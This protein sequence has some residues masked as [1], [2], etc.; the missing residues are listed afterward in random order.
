MNEIRLGDL[1]LA[2][3]EAGEGPPLVLLH[4]GLVDSRSWRWQLEGLAGDFRVLAWDAPGFGRSSDV[5]ESWRMED[6]ADAAAVWIRALGVERPHLLGLS[7]GSSI[8]LEVY[9]RH[10]DLPASLIL[11][12]AYAGWAG[13]LPP[14][15]VA[16]RLEGALAAAGL[17]P[18]EM[19]ERW[20]GVFSAAATSAVREELMAIWADNAGG[21]NPGGYRASVRSMADADLRNVLPRIRIP[22]LLLYGELDDRSPLPVARELHAGI[23]GSELVVLPGVGHMTSAEAPDAFDAEVRRFIRACEEAR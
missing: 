21:R 4:G 5:P 16:A 1:R 23:P 10:P 13:S 3:A 2:Y 11:A 9:R 6:F 20:S 22:T 18:R 15:Q 14:D 7:W 8:A 12:S 17:P 19:V